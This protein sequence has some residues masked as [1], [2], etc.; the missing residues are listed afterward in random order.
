MYI[1]PPPPLHTQVVRKTLAPCFSTD[2]LKKYFPQARWV[3]LESLLMYK[4]IASCAGH[5]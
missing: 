2:N 3:L 5:V 1:I 4:S